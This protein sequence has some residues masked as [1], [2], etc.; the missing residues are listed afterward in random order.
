M[1]E[2]RMR[3]SWHCK[4]GH[5]NTQV[6]QFVEGSFASSASCDRCGEPHIL[7][8]VA[9]VVGW[10]PQHVLQPQFLIG[11]RVENESI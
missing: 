1:I 4:C 10:T 6:I 3:F 9:S 8:S 5:L 2:V 11:K 7:A